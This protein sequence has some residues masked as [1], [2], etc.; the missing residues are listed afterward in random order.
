MSN[1]PAY[2]RGRGR[3]RGGPPVPQPAV[4]PGFGA[5]GAHPIGRN[6]N[7]QSKP[8]SDLCGAWSSKNQNNASP[9]GV[10]TAVVYVYCVLNV[11]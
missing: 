3:G 6:N 9:K 8:G 2:L 4:P 5:A 10:Y 1:K 11:R 7:K